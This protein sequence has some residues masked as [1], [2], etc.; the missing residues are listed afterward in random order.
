MET[1]E[2]S[3]QNLLPPE[4]RAKILRLVRHDKSVLVKDL[5]ARFGVTGE[6]IRKDL[7]LM[8]QEGLLIKTYGGAYIQEGVK[9]EVDASIRKTLLPEIKDAIGAY[10][11]GLVE[12]GDTVFLDASTTCLS[13]ARHLSALNLTVVTNS[14]DIA[15]LFS[16]GGKCKLLLSGGE[17]DS[18]NRCFVGGGTEEFLS[19]YYVD[20]S[21]VSCR[22]ADQTAGITDGSDVHGRIRAMMLQRARKRYLVLD[23][24]KLGHVNFFRVCGFD[25]IDSVLADSFPDDGGWPEFLSGQ[26]IEVIEIMPKSEEG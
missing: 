12:E 6:T 15:E 10:C 26:G 7:S 18:K 17:L 23:H 20:K 19:R 13:V 16:E 11:V 4:R 14:L 5:C 9:N 24:T 2:N 3:S 8:E 22:A 25:Q 1:S 21:F